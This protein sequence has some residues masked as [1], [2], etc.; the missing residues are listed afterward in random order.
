MNK[1]K[2]LKVPTEGAPK[3]RLYTMGARKATKTN[4]PF[5]MNLTSL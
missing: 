3:D 1:I 5:R 2:I 4:G